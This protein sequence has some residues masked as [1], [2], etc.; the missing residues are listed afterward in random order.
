MGRRF[1]SE[2]MYVLYDGNCELCKSAMARFKKWDLFGRITFISALDKDEIAAHGLGWLDSRE[3]LQNMHAVK[4][5][6]VWT[7]FYAYRALA[8]RL[9]ILWLLLPFLYL[10]PVP[11]FGRRFYRKVADSRTCHLPHGNR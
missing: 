9:P 3:L 2:D 1:F 5:K 11:Y 10:W 6:R 4:G 8:A 7:G